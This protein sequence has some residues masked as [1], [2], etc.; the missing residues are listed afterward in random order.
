MVLTHAVEGLFL[1]FLLS[2]VEVV[3]EVDCRGYD[4][5]S[6]DEES[7]EDAEDGGDG[8]EERVA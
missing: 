8:Q 6:E 2:V 5:C 3:V 7:Y 4:D 1:G